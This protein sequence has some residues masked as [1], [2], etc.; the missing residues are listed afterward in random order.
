[1]S[2]S[3]QNISV[4][5]QSCDSEAD[6]SVWDDATHEEIDKT[7]EAL[8]WLV[9]K[10]RMRIFCADCRDNPEA[11]EISP[12]EK[13]HAMTQVMTLAALAG[14]ISSQAKKL[15]RTKKYKPAFDMVLLGIQ[16]GINSL[17]ISY[18]LDPLIVKQ[19]MKDFRERKFSVAKSIKAEEAKDEIG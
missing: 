14:E 12:V 16:N 2:P 11:E 4:F 9:S 6:I 13:D 8:G 1:M 10:D 3:F 18:E 15:G 19:K 17:I 7:I 5:C